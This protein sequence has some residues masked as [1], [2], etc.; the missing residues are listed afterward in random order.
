MESGSPSDKPVFAPE[1]L[2]DANVAIF[3]RQSSDG[4]NGGCIANRSSDVIGISNIFTGKGAP[5]ATVGAIGAASS[6]FG[7]KL[8]LVGYENGD[9]LTE[10]LDLG[11]DSLAPLRIWIRTS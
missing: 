3:G 7:S 9:A 8:P 2:S 5:S 10:M 11:F 1:I 4:F 6:A